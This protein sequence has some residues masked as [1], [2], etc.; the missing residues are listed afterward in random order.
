MFFKCWILVPT[1][2][3]VGV[4]TNKINILLTCSWLFSLCDFK[5]SFILLK[6]LIIYF[7]LAIRNGPFW[8]V[9]VKWKNIFIDKELVPYYAWYFSRWIHSTTR[10][11]AIFGWS[12]SFRLWGQKGIWSH[13]PS[14]NASMP[15]QKNL[16]SSSKTWRPRTMT[17]FQRKWNVSHTLKENFNSQ[18]P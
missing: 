16:S 17:S 7:M 13:W 4:L 18:S 8:D 12:L 10:V 9:Q 11:I 1:M 2:N 14:P 6:R 3:F 15:L 5:N